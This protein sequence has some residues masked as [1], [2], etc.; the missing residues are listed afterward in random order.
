MANPELTRQQADA[1]LDRLDAER[2][3]ISSALVEIDNH[4]GHLLL[5]AATLRGETSRRWPPA[6]AALAGVHQLFESYRDALDRAHELRS[7]REFGELTELLRGES[8]ELSNEALPLRQRSLTGPSAVVE[9]VGLVTAVERMNTAFSL[10]TAVVADADAIWSAI[11]PRLDAAQEVLREARTLAGRL[12]LTETDPALAAELDRMHADVTGLRERLAADPLSLPLDA[13]EP[14]PDRARA[15][16]NRVAAVAS[17]RDGFASRIAATRDGLDRLRAAQAAAG[18]TRDEVLVKIAES[19]L[20]AVTDRSAALLARLD[21]LTALGADGRWR[22]LA[23]ELPAFERDVARAIDHV[24]TEQ[25]AI[26]SLL[27]RRDEL[28]GRLDAYRAKAA[29]IGHSEDRELD[30]LF[31]AAHELLWTA[32]CDL[33]A[34]T[35]ALARYQQ[36]VSA[37]EGARHG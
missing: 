36:E 37:R 25:D 15:V 9:R 12:A 24:R 27:D 10:V 8:I 4:P 33:P 11:V 35:R 32:P 20:P 3:A 1:E 14:L 13:G 30:R 18:R 22:R 17:L 16:L 19:A 6:R 31:G 7:R 29:G 28:R 21:A 34:A 2:S 26:G 23:D 5:E